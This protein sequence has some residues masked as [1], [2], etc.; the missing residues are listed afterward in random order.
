MVAFLFDETA[1]RMKE[2]NVLQYLDHLEFAVVKPGFGETQRR[3]LKTVFENFYP[4]E[5]KWKINLDGAE[6]EHEGVPIKLKVIKKNIE[7]F[8]NPD[9]MFYRGREFRVPNQWDKYWRMR[10][11][12]G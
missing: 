10:K 2:S 3:L 9:T 12:I 5:L 1:Q 4:A 6:F 11:V 8:S 7:F